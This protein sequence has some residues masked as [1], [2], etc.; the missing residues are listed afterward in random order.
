MDN[1]T[2]I[3]R[4]PR[5][6][7]FGILL[8]SSI[9]FFFIGTEKYNTIKIS[10]INIEEISQDININNRDKNIDKIYDISK[11]KSD[12]KDFSWVKKNKE[13][14]NI[15][16]NEV[17]LLI[18]KM[19]QNN[20]NLEKV[21]FNKKIPGFFVN[22]LPEDIS[23]IRDTEQK[24][25]LFISIVL[26]LIVEVNRDLKLKRSRL[27]KLYD[28]LS[29]DQTLTLKEHRWLINLALENS[30]K[31]S[32][33]NK[34]EI[35]KNLLINIDIIPNSIAIAQA[36]KE[37]GWGTS[38]FAIEGNALFGQWTFNNS[39]G[40]IPK[41]RQ[42]GEDHYVKSFVNL[43]ESV[44]SYMKNINTHKA[45]KSF[46]EKRFQYRQNNRSLD[47][48]VLVHELSSYAEL[49]N[50]TEILQLIIE[51][52]ELY[53]FDDVKLIINNSLV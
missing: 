23:Y 4:L 27:K 11:L 46:R 31:I 6:F 17:A 10:E 43:K 13:K 12:L 51:K 22:E 50:Y 18:N 52:N 39:N 42:V 20:Y 24:K 37:S 15:N 38:R 8:L 7:F 32:Q 45:Y 36:A 25:K 19:D 35:A 41:E 34:I 47:P 49:N 33:I 40:L 5:I 21:I 2:L 53:I 16:N 28:K 1:I 3:N 14:V 26:P 30:I 9:Y 44:K 29:Q 48:I